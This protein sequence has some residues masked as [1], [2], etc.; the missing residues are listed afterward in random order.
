MAARCSSVPATSRVDAAWWIPTKASTSRGAS[1]AANS[2]YSTT[3]S[4]TDMPPP[5]SEG[6][7]G[8]A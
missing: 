4:A 8:T 1:W 3:C 7:C 5:H 2:W 6:Q